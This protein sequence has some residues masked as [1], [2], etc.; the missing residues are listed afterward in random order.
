MAVPDKADITG[1]LL[2]FLKT[3]ILE[4]DIDITAQTSFDQL[5]IDSLS[6]IELVLFI[7]RKFQVIIPED[8]L[9]PENL[10]S[11]ESL[12]ACTFRNLPA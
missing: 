3:S 4:K 2:T 10:N 9:L 8:E 7:E 12:A 6:I 5:G 1:A 11:V